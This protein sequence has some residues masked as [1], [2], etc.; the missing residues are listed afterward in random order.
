VR[1]SGARMAAAGA[2]ALLVAG[3]SMDPRWADTPGPLP[4]SH[5][6]RERQINAAWQNHTMRELVD[7]WGAPRQM[8]DIPGGGNPPGMVLVYRRDAVT[9]CLDTFAVMYGDVMRV[10]SY[11]CR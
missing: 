8:L 7:D 1:D 5:D 9:G 2:L 3:C 11:Q 10:R 6:A 4:V